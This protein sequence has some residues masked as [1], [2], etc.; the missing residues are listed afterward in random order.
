M[1]KLKDF[2]EHLER[3]AE[4]HSIYVW[5]AQGQDSTV[6]NEKWIRKMEN[7][8]NNARR[9]INFW[10][11]QVE[12]GFGKV[13]RAFDCSG[14]GMAFLQNETGVVKSD[15]SANTMMGKCELIPKDELCRGCWVFKVNSSGRATHIG[16]VVDDDLNVIEAKGRDYGVIKSHLSKSSWNRFGIPKYF[17]DEIKPAEGPKLTLGRVL[18]VTSPLMRGEDVKAVQREL[19]ALNYHCGSS[20]IDGLFGKDTEKAVK[21]FQAEKKLTVDGKVGRKTIVALGGKWTG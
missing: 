15:M 7:S 19:T 8:D 14:L 17:A 2:I 13:L 11:K 4:N 5:G 16:Y 1:T 3:E 20:G 9:A 10:K 12:A 6:I 18:K 21:A